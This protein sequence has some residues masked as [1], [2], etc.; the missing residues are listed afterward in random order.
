[1]VR[2]F[3]RIHSKVLCGDLSLHRHVPLSQYVHGAVHFAIS[4]VPTKS[5]FV[6]QYIDPLSFLL[7]GDTGSLGL[8]KPLCWFQLL[9]LHSPTKWAFNSATSHNRHFMSWK[10]NTC[11]PFE[12]PSSESRTYTKP[13]QEW[14]ICT[15]VESIT[16][17]SY[18]SNPK[19]WFTCSS[20]RTHC[21]VMVHMSYTYCTRTF[22][23]LEAQ[24]GE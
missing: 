18:L 1:M 7:R 4:W 23:L 13:E 14:Y 22:S 24:Y 19:L 2:F 10:S 16:L 12:L 17:Y 8:S 6:S 9:T 21:I 3:S 5:S 20:K 11:V 15:Y